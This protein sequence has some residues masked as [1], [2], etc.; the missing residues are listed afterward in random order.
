MHVPTGRVSIES[1]LRLLL[2]DLKVP[3]ARDHV[4]D[5]ADVLDASERDFIEHRRWHS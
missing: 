5:F 2:T 4:S 3:P 1:V